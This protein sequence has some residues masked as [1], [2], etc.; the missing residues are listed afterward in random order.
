[1]R[2]PDYK[3]RMRSAHDLTLTVRLLFDHEVAEWVREAPSFFQVAA[4]DC[5]EGLV[6]TL[7]CRQFNE[8]TQWLLSWGAHLQVLE[9][10]ELRELLADEIRAML[11]NYE[12]GS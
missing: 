5:P 12:M 10:L 4:E 2:P 6:V 11:R 7:R 8:I 9:P 3:I 1:M